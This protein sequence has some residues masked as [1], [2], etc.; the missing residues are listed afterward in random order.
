MSVLNVTEP[1]VTTCAMEPLSYIIYNDQRERS[2]G[3]F[4]QHAIT[5][6]HITKAIKMKLRKQEKGAHAV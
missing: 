6:R 3:V 4:S 5:T 2:F 1:C